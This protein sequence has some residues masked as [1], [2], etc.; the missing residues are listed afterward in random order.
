MKLYICISFMQLSAHYHNQVRRIASACN[1][2][3]RNVN[4]RANLLRCNQCE[5]LSVG[6]PAVM[7]VF[8]W[9]VIPACLMRGD[10]WMTTVSRVYLEVKLIFSAFVV[11]SQTFAFITVGVASVNL[12]I[13]CPAAAVRRT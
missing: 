8:W 1:A 5:T 11:C 2:S 4:I 12:A 3:L 6:L 9:C 7:H 10:C 13:L